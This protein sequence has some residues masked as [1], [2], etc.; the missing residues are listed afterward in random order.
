MAKIGSSEI[1]ADEKTYFWEKSHG[2][3][4]LAKFFLT[5]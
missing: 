3:V 2:K 4:S 5:V 1:L